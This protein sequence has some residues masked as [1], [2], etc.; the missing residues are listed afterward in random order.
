MVGLNKTG[1]INDLRPN[2]MYEITAPD[3]TSILPKPRWRWSK[4]KFEKCLKEGRVVFSKTKNGWSVSYKQYF[5][6]DTEGNPVD[7]GSLVKS[8]ITDCGRTT[9]GSN[10]LA[11]LIGKGAFDFPK[12]VDLIKRL[13]QISC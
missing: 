10:E 7:R 1:T 4:E 6:E 5:Y 12:P 11:K 2:L 8:I 13:L 9:N 3:G